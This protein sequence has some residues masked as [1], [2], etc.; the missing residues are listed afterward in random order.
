MLAYPILCRGRFILSLALLFSLGACTTKECGSVTKVN[1]T[2]SFDV[3]I[4][5]FNPI[6]AAGKIA[7]NAVNIDFNGSNQ[8]LA[9]AIGTATMEKDENDYISAET[10]AELETQ[11]Q[12][13]ATNWLNN[14]SGAV[15]NSCPNN[16]HKPCK[17]HANVKTEFVSASIIRYKSGSPSVVRM[18]YRIVGN[19]KC[20]PCPT[21]GAQQTSSTIQDP[22]S[23]IAC[24]GAANSDATAIEDSSNTRA[25]LSMGGDEAI[26]SY[27]DGVAIHV[28]LS[29]STL[30]DPVV[31]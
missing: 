23:E 17:A 22:V 24:T 10:K 3:T 7:G 18:K 16:A 26:Y 1:D 29:E 15:C 30:L 11:A 19:F 14:N 8:G 12:E 27:D 21:C 9:T 2:I 28:P 31:Q 6:K 20:A 13:F 5:E 4:H 25:T